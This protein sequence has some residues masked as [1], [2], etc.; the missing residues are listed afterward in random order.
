LSEK[1]TP[2]FASSD[3]PAPCETSFPWFISDH[4]GSGVQSSL[5]TLVF[6]WRLAST[7]WIFSHACGSRFNQ[8]VSSWWVSLFPLGEFRTLIFR[9][10]NWRGDWGQ[11]LLLSTLGKP[12]PAPGHCVQTS[13]F[14]RFIFNQLYIWFTGELEPTSR[15]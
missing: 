11:T 4:L 13:R 10:P 7:F 12:S 5:Q 6:R 15:S 2:P 9:S 1:W 14:I 8:A 3:R